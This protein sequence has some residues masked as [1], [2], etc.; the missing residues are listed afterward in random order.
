MTSS[1]IVTN[2]A[3]TKV[4]TNCNAPTPET[5]PACKSAPAPAPGTMKLVLDPVH[6][7]FLSM[8]IKTSDEKPYN[9]HEL[10]MINGKWLIL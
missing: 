3:N 2:D 5:V 1:R 9:I 8:N 6:S 4:S 7:D 10:P